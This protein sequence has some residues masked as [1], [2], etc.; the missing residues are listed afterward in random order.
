MTLAVLS[1]CSLPAGILLM[2]WLQPHWLRLASIYYLAG[3]AW[4]VLLLL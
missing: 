3:A 1:G 4:M 2:R